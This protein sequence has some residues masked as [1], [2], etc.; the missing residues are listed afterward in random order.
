MN[1]YTY[2]LDSF[3]DLHKE[4]YGFRPSSTWYEWMQAASPDEL[5]EQW[6]SL[7]RSAEWAFQEE[8]E[9]REQA[10]TDLNK[11]IAEMQRD[12]KVDMATCIRWLHD[13]YKTAGDD[14]YLEYHLGVAYGTIAKLLKGA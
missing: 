7:V 14:G 9:L 13:A 6:D 12:H 3:S 8:Q 5:Q 4:A 2:D 1:Q 10:L 11:T